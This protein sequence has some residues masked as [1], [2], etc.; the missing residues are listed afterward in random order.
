MPETGAESYFELFG[1]PPSYAIDLARLGRVY[2][3]LQRN[4]H[5]DRFANS[6]DQERRLAMHQAARINAA[7]QVLADPL[8]RGRYLLELHGNHFDAEHS[9]TRSVEFLTEQMELR[10]ALAEVRDHDAPPGKLVEIMGRIS[11]RLKQSEG[12]LHDYLR[13]DETGRLTGP[14]ESA[15]DTVLKMK[16]YRRLQEEAQDLE[17]ELN[18]DLN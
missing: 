18:H 2:R 16:Y 6:S 13:L 15:V 9:I 1:L 3:I 5:P 14:V 8:S 11:D 7:Y 4:M 10:E 12:L 17:D